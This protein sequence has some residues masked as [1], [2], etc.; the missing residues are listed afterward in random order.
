MKK[1]LLLLGIVALIVGLWLGLR[2]SSAKLEST[3]MFFF[4]GPTFADHKVYELNDTASVLKHPSFDT[5]RPTVLY[6][7][8]YL[9]SME[10][11]SI[12]VIADAYLARG[13]HN[14]L[15]LDWAEL[16]DGNYLIDAFPNLKPLA[17]AL[18]GHILKMAM[19]GMRLDKFHVVGHSMGGQLAGYIGREVIK[20]SEKGAKLK[21]ITALDPAFPGFYFPLKFTGALNSKDADL[22][23]VI[24]TDAWLYGAPFATGHVDFW[25]NRGKTLQ[26]GC[27]KR[28][29]K[30]LT[31]NDLCSHRRSWR[32]WAE[33]VTEK[34]R[35]SFHAV[36]CASWDKF[37]AGD[38]DKSEPAVYMGIDCPAGISGNY[39]L[40]TNGEPPYSKGSA[41]ASYAIALSN[42]SLGLSAAST[43]TLRKRSGLFQSRDSEPVAE[44]EEGEGVWIHMERHRPQLSTRRGF[45]RVLHMPARLFVPTLG[46]ILT[47]IVVKSGCGSPATS[48]HSALTLWPVRISHG[49][50]TNTAVFDLNP[51]KCIL[52]RTNV[53]PHE[54]IDFFMF[55]NAVR[56]GRPIDV[57]YPKTIA[58]AGFQAKH[59]SVIIIHGF[60]GTQNSKHIMYLK[61]AYL[62]RKFNVITVDWFRLT[63]YP[64][65]VTALTNTRV[66]A[67][68]TAQVYAFLTHLGASRHRITCV[69][70]SLGAH[71]CGMMGNHL[72]SRQYKIIGLDPARPLVETHADNTFRLTRDDAKVVQ[73]I[74][75]NAGKLGQLSSSGTVDFCVNGGRQQPY[76]KGHPIRE[77]HKL[78]YIA[79]NPP[80]IWALPS[81][82]NHFLSVCY[83]A[84]IL[85]HHK[86][87]IG[88]PC[89][90]G[91][92]YVKR[93]RLPIYTKNI[94]NIRNLVRYMQ[95]GQDTPDQSNAH[96]RIITIKSLYHL[97]FA[98][99]C[100]LFLPIFTTLALMSIFHHDARFHVLCVQMWRCDM[101]EE[102]R[103][104]ESG[105]SGEEVTHGAPHS[106]SSR[107]GE[108]TDWQCFGII[109]LW[110]TGDATCA[111]R[112]RRMDILLKLYFCTTLLQCEFLQD[113]SAQGIIAQALYL[114]DPNMYNNTMDSCI[115]KRGNDRD[116]CPDPDIN[117]ILYTGGLVRRKTLLDMD[118]ADWLRNSGFNPNY[119]SIILIHG[120][121]GG[122]D[123]LPMV[124]LRDAYI[125]HGNYNVFVA[126][127]GPLAQPPCYVAAVHNLR[128]VA[129]CFAKLFT[130]LRDSGLRVEK[131]TCV[132]H[133]LGAHVCGLM[134]N[135]LTFRLEKIIG[136]DPARP[137]VKLGNAF[138]LDSG[139]AKAVQVLHTNA[140]HYGESGRI[141]HVDFCINNGKRQPFC[142][143]TT[144]TFGPSA[145]WAPQY[146]PMSTASRAQDAAA[147]QSED[148][149]C[150]E[151][152]EEFLQS[153][154]PLFISITCDF[155]GNSEIIVSVSMTVSRTEVIMLAHVFKRW[156]Q[157]AL[158][159]FLAVIVSSIPIAVE[160]RSTLRWGPC[161]WVVDRKCPD[162]DIK[163]FLF[164]SRNP[165]ERQF[166]YVDSTWEKSNIS[167]SFFNP[168]HPTKIIIHGYNSDMYLNS[169]I[170]M[171][172][173]YLQR[174]DFNLFFIDWSILGQSPCYLMAVH[175]AD[176]VGKCIAQLIHR[177]LETETTDIHLIG[178][179]L[180]G[181]VTNF[182]AKHAKPFQI[183]R[184][185][186]LDPALPLYIGVSNDEKLDPS[187]ALFV[188]VL[189]TNA[190]V[191]GKIERS[192]HADFYFNGGILQ[193]GCWSNGQN[194]IVCSH[195]RAPDYYMESIRSFR[196]FWGWQCDS[197]INYLLGFCKPTD[198]LREA[199]ENCKNTT[200]G[201]F[202]VNT[203]PSSPFAMGKWTDVLKN[204]G[205]KSSLLD[206]YLAPIKRKNPLQ[207]ELNQWGKLDGNFNNIMNFP[208]P[209]PQD[210]LN[211]DWVYFSHHGTK[212]I[213]EHLFG[214]LLAE[215]LKGVNG[216][217]IVDNGLELENFMNGQKLQATTESAKN[218]NNHDHITDPI[219]YRDK[220][221][222]EYVR[223]VTGYDENFPLPLY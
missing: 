58:Q 206:E 130:F 49:I 132:G 28:N 212:H 123:T 65:Y 29:Y 111:C 53:C 93:N 1:L 128:P 146:S 73:V 178:F 126:D 177:I 205:L 210:P 23:D 2:S 25:P 31:D 202:L 203:N 100:A 160:Q 148:S 144:T 207:E 57:R 78:N 46:V 143:T 180:G 168:L 91:C 141:G 98:P 4:Y 124:V 44:N 90:H 129:R 88:V 122:D 161:I 24:H 30:M 74:H 150:G 113:T 32:F 60:N 83:L 125:R 201:L 182:V 214:N 158:F 139:D 21:R 6:L 66:V 45:S 222:K 67:Q 11:E 81:G 211:D 102:L 41:G 5:N 16:A 9:E 7:H 42:G 82:G 169:L 200:R 51:F 64:C 79:I 96:C 196:G 191:Q 62:S 167:T 97:P 209:L 131:T 10:V 56:R 165:S 220:V 174:G 55:T 221:I 103:Y 94:F 12:Q 13:D 92:V 84:N 120:Y 75:T 149:E 136:L 142:S 108:R 156:I 101:N 152:V 80:L 17:S 70:H 218:A 175:N 105:V 153:K 154:L 213:T 134:A 20:Q 192:G 173:E 155:A 135:Y 85:F 147:D 76:C 204:S 127:W 33:S 163:I 71:I 121:A 48:A 215:S 194:P 170:E 171:R 37:K 40:Q 199:G 110:A 188:D 176:H 137:L 59:E 86:K 189:H 208:T 47:A 217:D 184:I 34:N 197:Y 107:C 183:P 18:A 50:F 187:D 195:H 38:C 8:G 198:V 99:H 117:M 19:D 193:P 190:L 140:G 68:C 159:L 138:R 112:R 223:N 145:T 162:S 219:V 151:R 133:S 52:S 43:H 104:G 69:G 3:R 35:P 87:V 109:D 61:D 116:Q 172:D 106:I 89:P 54:E 115:W 26:P 119:E 14:T 114:G 77:C 157:I 39:Y 36:K 72:T 22:V 95:I 164:T 181:Q 185:T 63:Q 15:I 118:Q 186:G 216:E 179:S 166:I 27:P